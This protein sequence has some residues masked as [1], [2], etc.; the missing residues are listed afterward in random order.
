M[1]SVAQQQPE[2]KG[3]FVT[4]KTTTNL[5]VAGFV[6]LSRLRPGVDIGEDIVA[7]KSKD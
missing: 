7:A 6:V 4:E 5:R 3:S 1:G 2:E